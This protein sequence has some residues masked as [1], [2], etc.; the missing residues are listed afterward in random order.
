M[1][2][3]CWLTLRR[4]PLTP[5]LGYFISSLRF[6]WPCIS[7]ADPRLPC[8]SSTDWGETSTVGPLIGRDRDSLK[9]LSSAD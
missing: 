5:L 9:W 4:R 6:I 1:Y 7:P 3:N 8:T 2:I